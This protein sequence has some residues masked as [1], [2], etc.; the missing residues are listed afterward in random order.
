MC[1]LCKQVVPRSYLPKHEDSECPEG[2]IA[3][4]FAD[5]GCYTKVYQYSRTCILTLLVYIVGDT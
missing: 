4:A 5:V 3:C 1:T 2:S